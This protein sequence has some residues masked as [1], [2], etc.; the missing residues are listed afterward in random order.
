MD[1]QPVCPWTYWPI[2]IHL[3][4]CFL[5]ILITYQVTSI[6]N[7]E[8]DK[9]N[10][11]YF[12][13]LLILPEYAI[14]ARGKTPSKFSDLTVDKSILHS[15]QD[16]DNDA[17]AAS[18]ASAAAVALAVPLSLAFALLSSFSALGLIHRPAKTSSS[19]S[20]INAFPKTNYD[21]DF[22]FTCIK[23]NF[24]FCKQLLTHLFSDDL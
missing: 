1:P 7:D 10:V 9:F 23:K 20:A 18:A 3:A 17:E 12:T 6:V 22:I 15:R 24:A 14:Q 11:F 19:L 5:I 13:N 21:G 2:T 16:D 4:T 8:L